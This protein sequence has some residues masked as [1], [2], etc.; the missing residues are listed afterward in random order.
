[1]KSKAR[2]TK[3][4][5]VCK[6]KAANLSHNGSETTKHYDYWSKNNANSKLYDGLAKW[7]NESST[8]NTKTTLTTQDSYSY[9]SEIKKSKTDELMA[10]VG[11]GNL[12]KTSKNAFK[13][14]NNIKPI[15]ANNSKIVKGDS[16]HKRISSEI[17][18]ISQF[19]NVD[20]D[21]MQN[22]ANKGKY[23]K[24]VD[25]GKDKSIFWFSDKFALPKSPKFLK[26]KND[27]KDKFDYE[28]TYLATE[29]MDGYIDFF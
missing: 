21:S 28:K 25:N 12:K 1:M 17:S 27:N 20:E 13:N 16:K 29:H 7:R 26:L 15:A 22:E 4:V 8:V 9:T 19:E 6:F 3:N 23:W 2:G 24:F 5:S 18:N 10:L 11:L 14:A